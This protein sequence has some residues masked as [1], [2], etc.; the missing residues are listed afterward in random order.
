MKK[1]LDDEFNHGISVGES[2]GAYD[3]SEEARKA[4]DE[5]KIEWWIEKQRPKTL[6]EWETWK[7]E[8]GPI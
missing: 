3:T 6:E 5:G 4:H 7:A 8:N 2:I 1:R